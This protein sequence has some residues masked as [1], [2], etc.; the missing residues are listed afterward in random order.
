MF[1]FIILAYTYK[2]E[3]EFRGSC[4]MADV[5]LQVIVDLRPLES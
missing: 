3:V 5:N 1:L 2:S 4:R